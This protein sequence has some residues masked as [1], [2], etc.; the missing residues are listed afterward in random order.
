MLLQRIFILLAAALL[1]SPGVA[2]AAAPV[3]DESALLAAAAQFDKALAG[4]GNATTAAVRGF[5]ALAAGN[6]PR[7]PLYLAYL[8]AVQS[9]QGRDAWMPWTKL[10]ATERGLATLDKALRALEP[11]HDAEL[12][13]GT[14]ISLWVRLIAART[15]LAVPELMFH[16]SERARQVLKAAL[17]Q[18]GFAAAPGAVRAAVH[19]QAAIAAGREGNIAAEAE[20]LRKA[21]AAAGSGAIVDASQKRLKEIGA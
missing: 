3:A 20:Q 4:D 14:A 1:L 6:G 5:E 12:A 9:L 18:P 19:Q 8:G 15:F 10:K 11:R 17:A 2:L 13:R 7:A 16:R 21:I